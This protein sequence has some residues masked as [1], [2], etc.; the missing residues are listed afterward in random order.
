MRNIK[1]ELVTAA[2]EAKDADLSRLLYRAE[3]V[4]DVQ[5]AII[6]QQKER[7]KAAMALI[8]FMSILVGVVAFMAGRAF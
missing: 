6:A 3:M 1:K 8:V 5:D 4:I 7:A 2:W